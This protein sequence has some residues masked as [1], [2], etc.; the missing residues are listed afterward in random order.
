MEA[1][2]VIR[3]AVALPTV[4]VAAGALSAVMSLTVILRLGNRYPTHGAAHGRASAL[5]L[6]QPFH[7]L[8][9]W[10]VHSR[11]DV[12]FLRQQFGGLLSRGRSAQ[13]NV[14]SW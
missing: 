8:C 11:P 2:A 5:L 10:V 6:K 1:A 14:F 9:H 4:R 12:K 7:A 3:T 13:R